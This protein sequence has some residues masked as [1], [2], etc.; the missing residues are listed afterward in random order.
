MGFLLSLRGMCTIH[1][2]IDVATVYSGLE[3]DI[4]MVKLSSIILLKLCS[5]SAVLNKFP[6]PLSNTK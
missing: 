2:F 5:I 4:E 3:Y 6:H 1:P